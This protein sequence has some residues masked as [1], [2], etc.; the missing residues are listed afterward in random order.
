MKTIVSFFDGF[1][2]M[3]DAQCS[4]T[5]MILKLIKADEVIQQENRSMPQSTL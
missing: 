3:S 2:D 1:T 5:S 4:P